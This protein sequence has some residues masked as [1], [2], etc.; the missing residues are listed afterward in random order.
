MSFPLVRYTLKTPT[1]L[2]DM[3]RLKYRAWTA[4]RGLSGSNRTAKGSSKDSSMSRFV[5]EPFKPKGGLFQSKSINAYAYISRPCNVLTLYLHTG[6]KSVNS[7]NDIFRE[8][9]N[10]RVRKGETLFANPRLDT[11]SERHEFHEFARTAYPFGYD[12]PY[13]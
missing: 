1:P 10:Q 13:G 11:D 2:T 12:D 6:G 8:K 5:K 9:F 3:P 4:N 7:K